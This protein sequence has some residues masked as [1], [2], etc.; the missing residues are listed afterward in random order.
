MWL[1]NKNKRKQFFFFLNFLFLCIFSFKAICEEQKGHV[2]LKDLVTVKGVRENS[3]LGHGL[4]VG[5]NGT[6]DGPNELSVNNMKNL[7]QKLGV[8]LQKDFVTKN[9]AVVIVT[10]KLPPFPR[11][12]QKLDITISSIG[13]ASSLA[14]G[15]L[16]ATPLQAGDG[17]VYAVGSGE[18]SIGGL[19]KGKKFPTVGIIAGG[20]LVEA[21]IPIDFENKN[22]LRFSLNNPDFT[23][24]ARLEKTIN[25]ELSGLYAKAKDPST[26]DIVIPESFRKNPVTLMAILENIKIEVESVA[27]ILINERT[28]TIVAGGNIPLRAVALAHGDLS[29][30]IVPEK[31]TSAGG[32]AATGG[33][34]EG[35]SKLGSKS[36]DF[37]ESKTTLNDLVK[38]LNTF[39]VS[40]QDLIAI[41]QSLKKS[42][43]IHAQLEFF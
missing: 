3:L 32:A 42:G 29:V 35:Q 23:T 36:F 12:G 38:A 15:T 4:V 16:L 33:G 37:I 10:A 19:E 30:K 6:G 2:F 13:D 28:G 27:K 39:G 24:A 8:N 17:K 21:E 40:P 22:F 7:F 9:V 18:I 41:I 26:I 31:N 34:G 1:D 20:A 5:L 14:G 25:Q 11:L 43:A